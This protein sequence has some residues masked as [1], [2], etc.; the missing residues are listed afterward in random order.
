MNSTARMVKL[1]RER[2]GGGGG[3]GGREGGREE[4]IRGDGEREIN[5]QKRDTAVDCGNRGGGGGDGVR[6]DLERRR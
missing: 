2:R 4:I 6:L 3:G 1:M 5:D